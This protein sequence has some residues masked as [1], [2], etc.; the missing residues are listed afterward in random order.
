MNRAAILTGTYY[1]LPCTILHLHHY[2]RTSVP[3]SYN[4]S[5]LQKSSLDPVGTAE[6]LVKAGI[7]NKEYPTFLFN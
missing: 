3:G 7:G 5:S 2:R 1:K 4:N 6:K